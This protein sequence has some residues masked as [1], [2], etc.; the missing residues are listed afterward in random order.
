MTSSALNA[1]RG[2]PTI[3]TR[4]SIVTQI[5]RWVALYGE[6]PRAADLNP[7][8]ARWGN[9]EW[10]IDR[11]HK[12]DPDTGER[13][14]SLNAV[15][16]AFGGSLNEA[17]KAAGFTPNKSGPPARRTLV[18][19]PIDRMTMDPA[20]RAA[21][22]AAR[23][24]ARDLAERVAVRDRQLATARV[25]NDRLREERDAA[26]RARPVAAPKTKVVRERVRVEDTRAL[27]R[28]KAKL[29]KA[30]LAREVAEAAAREGRDLTRATARELS[31]ARARV[32]VL[33]GAVTQAE[34][35]A[36]AAQAL[37]KSLEDRLTVAESRRERVVI[38][39][40]V[41]QS[42]T[43]E[44]VDEARRVASEAERAADEAE[45]RAAKAERE[46]RE[47]AS[48]VRGE[49]RKLT[50]AELDEL[51][52]AGPSGPAVLGEALRELAVARRRRPAAVGV[53]L[54]KVAS[55]AVGWR[56]ALR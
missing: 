43:D 45:L 14:P 27:T 30:V 18:D 1:E 37:V 12:G 46:Y 33:D 56:D 6:P 42:A 24:E 54:G 22:D 9:Q 3:H 36:S 7:S 17:I 20:A 32:E 38:K 4:D 25:A 40:R 16:S 15:K 19:H 26:R 53:A 39:E 51:R 48:V 50:R 49:S 35:E 55:A 10:R 41:V 5:Q 31:R 44:E 28:L 23:A 52:A 2:R 8:A 34:A 47:L 21:L 13:W 29:D 11:Y